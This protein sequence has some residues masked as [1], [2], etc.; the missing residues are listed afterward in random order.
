MSVVPAPFGLGFGQLMSLNTPRNSVFTARTFQCLRS[1]QR[2]RKASG[3]RALRSVIPI[4][5]DS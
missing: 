3:K 4:R 1:S 2:D 5:H